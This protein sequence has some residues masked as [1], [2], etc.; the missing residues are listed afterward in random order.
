[1]NIFFIDNFDSFIYNLV[2]EF[3]KRKC[4]VLVYRNNTDIKLIDKVVK[5]F[6]PNLIVISPGPSHP[7]NAGICIKLIKNY[8]DKLPI[9]GICLGHQC[10]VEA[11]G[12]KVERCPETIHGKPSQIMH[13]G[14]GIFSLIENPFQA[15][16]YHSLYGEAIPEELEVSAE[17]ADRHIVMAVKHKKYNLFGVQFHPESILTPVG[18][19]IIDNLLDIIKL[20]AK[21]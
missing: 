16:R 13:D 19:K 11:L 21:K 20:E 7:R 17:T 5:D 9:F 4:D 10:I 12:G 1:M 14:A 3:K 18:G 6:K 2:D 8:F 15:G